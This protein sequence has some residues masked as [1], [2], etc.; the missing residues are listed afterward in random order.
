MA[1]SLTDGKPVWEPDAFEVDAD[2]LMQPPKP[3]AGKAGEKAEAWLRDQLKDGP[4][5]ASDLEA[6]LPGGF[7]WKTAD[8]VSR[9]IG[10]HKQ[11][12]GLQGDP[13]WMWSLN[14]SP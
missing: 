8:R 13:K 14:G 6:N 3:H 9:N 4:V 11:R 7:C 5:A 1:F 12:I 10:V 2:A